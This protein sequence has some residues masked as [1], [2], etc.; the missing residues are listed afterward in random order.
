MYVCRSVGSDD[1]MAVGSCNYINS[2]AFANAR[3]TP[4]VQV[5]LL[6]RPF[7]QVLLR[8]RDVQS[9]QQQQQ[10][11]GQQQTIVTRSNQQKRQQQHV[12]NKEPR[13][14]G[15][16]LSGRASPCAS[17]A[18]SRMRCEVRMPY[19]ILMVTGG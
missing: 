12:Y 13:K 6:W 18:C 5:R 2:R 16:V 3:T 10:Q 17:V 11:G 7:L 15:A 1:H 4:Q 8:T 14:L 19:P 9:P